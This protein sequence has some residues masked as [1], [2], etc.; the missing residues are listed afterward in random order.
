MLA[1]KNIGK[2]TS[3]INSD[4]AVVEAAYFYDVLTTFPHSF[5]EFRL[6]LCGLVLHA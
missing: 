2:L 5:S 1:C 3:S 4:M 6:E